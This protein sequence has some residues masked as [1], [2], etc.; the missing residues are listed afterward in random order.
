MIQKDEKDRLRRQVAMSELVKLSEEL[1]LYSP[2]HSE[3]KAETE[4]S[5]T[6]EV[7]KCTN[8]GYLTRV[9]DGSV[10]MAL[11]DKHYESWFGYSRR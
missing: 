7:Q 3:C 8:H 6:G 10:S 11:C 9:G 2:K 5:L 1:D 4:D